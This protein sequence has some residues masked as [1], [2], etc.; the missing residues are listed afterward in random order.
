MK[1][2]FKDLI[3]KRITQTALTKLFLKAPI[4]GWGPFGIVITFLIN[5][6]TSLLLNEIEKNID[7]KKV[8]YKNK[9][10][11]MF[12]DKESIKLKIFAENY[13]VNSEEY[14]KVKDASKV[15]LVKFVDLS[16]I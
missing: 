14:K 4:L 8:T 15:A 12:F 13:G 16:N 7:L 1:D 3:F 9:K 11:Q 2:L 6:Y 10:L 5:K